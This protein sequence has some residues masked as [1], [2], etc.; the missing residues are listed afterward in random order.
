L[1]AP[2][3]WAQKGI[4]VTPFVGGQINGG[5]SLSTSLYN[6]LDVQ[7]GLNYGDPQTALTR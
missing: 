2:A 1:T 5:V 7:N 3:V 6:N 4:E